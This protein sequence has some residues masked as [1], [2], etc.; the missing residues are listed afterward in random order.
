MKQFTLENNSASYKQK[1]VYIIDIAPTS[2]YKFARYAK[3]F[4]S[5]IYHAWEGVYKQKK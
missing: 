3:L 2:K 5:L 1:S 4:I